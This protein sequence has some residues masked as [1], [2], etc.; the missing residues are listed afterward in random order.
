MGDQSLRLVVLRIKYSQW[1]APWGWSNF[2]FSF[3]SSILWEHCGTCRFGTP[4]ICLA[5]TITIHAFSIHDSK[6]QLKQKK[7]HQAESTNVWKR[8]ERFLG[9]LII[10]LENWN[11]KLVEFWCL[12]VTCWHCAGHLSTE[13]ILHVN[14]TNFGSYSHIGK[15]PWTTHNVWC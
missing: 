9:R 4:S 10:N 11:W 5:N 14:S 3:S 13:I 8:K 15:I 12:T 7:C 1:A 2:G 6:T